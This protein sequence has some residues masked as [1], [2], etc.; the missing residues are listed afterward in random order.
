MTHPPRRAWRTDEEWDR[1]R[2]RIEGAP[3]VRPPRDVRRIAWLAAA[4]IV[5][6]GALGWQATRGQTDERVVTTA[7]GE[8]IIIRLADSSVITLGPL[9]TVRYSMKDQRRVAL[10]GLASFVVVHDTARPFVVTARNAV[11]TDLGTEFV[12][13][14]YATDSVVDVAVKSGIVAL[15]GASSTQP[16]ELRA[17]ELGRVHVNGAATRGASADARLA[18]IDGRLVFDDAS[19]REVAA[20][21]SRWF[22]VDVRLGEGPLANRRVSATYTSP[23]LDG[24]LEA[25]TASLDVRITRTGRT[26]T[27]TPTP[28]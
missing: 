15:T 20:E 27:I 12:V 16:V 3:L 26:I 6:A 4:G 19:L 10:D 1:L 9:S 25:L 7:A 18:W 5:I 13:R 2:E 11:A 22:D 24:V 21:V 8:R 28:Q 17:N 23:T 14:A